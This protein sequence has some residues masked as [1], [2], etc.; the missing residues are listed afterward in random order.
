MTEEYPV[1]K[2]GKQQMWI[3]HTLYTLGNLSIYLLSS[4]LSVCLSL[5]IQPSVHPSINLSMALQSFVWPW[6][7]FQFLDL[8]QSV[9]SLG[10]VISPSQGRDLHTGQHK[11]RINAH[12]H[13]C[14]KWDSIPRSQCSSDRRQFMPQTPRPLWSALGTV[15]RALLKWNIPFT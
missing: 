6:A 5:S 1:L 13:P 4:Y 14:L 2:I 11:L 15:S 7:L 10:R 9:G 8:L 12:R 3:R